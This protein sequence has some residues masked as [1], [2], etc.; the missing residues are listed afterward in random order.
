MTLPTCLLIE[1]L[2]APAQAQAGR[3]LL[4]TLVDQAAQLGVT[5]GEIVAAGVAA[6]GRRR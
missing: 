4:A 6:I 5:P 1:V 2:L 3:L